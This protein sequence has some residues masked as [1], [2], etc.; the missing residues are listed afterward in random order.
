M[1][2][3]KYINFTDTDITSILESFTTILNSIN[4]DRFIE[5]IN[6]YYKADIIK[7]PYNSKELTE[8][9]NNIISYITVK[10]SK[11]RIKTNLKLNKLQ[12]FSSIFED[13]YKISKNINFWITVLFDYNFAKYE[14]YDN[15]EN[16]EDTYKD[17]YSDY[18]MEHDKNKSSN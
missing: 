10:K 15:I 14:I 1:R 2:K 7:N 3:L 4:D 16:M 12:L 11:L 9:C 18:L 8:F 5:Y 6:T 13:D 17:M